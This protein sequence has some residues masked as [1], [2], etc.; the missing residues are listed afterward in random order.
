MSFSF[1]ATMMLIS[2]SAVIAFVL[3]PSEEELQAPANAPVSH[4]RCQRE[5]LQ[6]IR[7]SLLSELNL[8][9]EPQLP[10]GGLDLV[11][12]HWRRTFNNMARNAEDPAVLVVD[13]FTAS[14]EGGN[15]TGLKCCPLASEV[16]MTDLGWDSWVIHPPSLT[17]LTCA[18]C[19]PQGNV[20]QC[21]SSQS[22]TLDANLQ[23][24]CC[25]LTSMK[26]VPIVYVDQFATL[27][28]ASVQL[29]SNCKCGRSDMGPSSME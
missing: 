20:V 9:S 24:N 13:D 17:I 15:S 25:Q 27:T 1:V 2:S 23:P 14:A 12:K 19:D 28:M 11:R 16:F 22:S 26:M 6:S 4:H 3:L 21:P 10:A 5:P 18:L 7:K 29:P 8:Q